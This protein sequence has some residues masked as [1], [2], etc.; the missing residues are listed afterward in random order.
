MEAVGSFSGETLL[1]QPVTLHGI[2]LGQPVDL[3]LDAA[4]RRA[5]GLVVRCGDES[6]RFLPWAAMQPDEAETRVASSLM[7][8]EDV[9]FYRAR[10]DSFREL[11]GGVVRSHGADVGGLKDLEL[12]RDGAIG[13]VVAV[14][15]GTE[16]R[17]PPEHTSLSSERAAA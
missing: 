13:V 4:D 1:R 17:L 16:Q 15:A 5:L 6:E 8:L 10:G 2:R 11:L 7:L 3:L 9:G 14:H 12:E